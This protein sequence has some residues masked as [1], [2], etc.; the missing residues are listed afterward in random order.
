MAFTKQVYHINSRNRLTGTDSDFT[1]AIDLKNFDPSHCVVLQANIP[2]SFYIVQDG[3]NTFTLTEEGGANSATVTIP[4]GNYSRLS[5]RTALQTLLN[6][7]S[8]NGYTYAV[9][10]PTTSSASDTGKFTFTCVGHTLESGFT[11]A[12]NNNIFELMGFD[13]GSANAF[14]GGSLVSTNVIKL[15][16]EDTIY[17]RTDLV[18][19]LSGGILQ[20]IYSVDSNDFSNIV[21][22]QFAHEYYEKEINTSNSNAFRFY[23]TNEDGGRL[24]L[25]GLNWNL[26]LCC[27]KKDNS[28]DA[29]R[30]Y[31]KYSFI[32]SM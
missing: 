10:T 11:F 14:V 3:Y 26:T 30:Q 22:Q 24:D 20:E 19:G 5:F 2:K 13:A 9:T 6:T 23:L 21:F 1:Y 12:A 27:Y 17:I 4:V 25:N 32:S 29:I 28:L 8:P 15:S 7:S 31:M 16:K 18:G